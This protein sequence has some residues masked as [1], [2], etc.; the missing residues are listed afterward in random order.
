METDIPISSIISLQSESNNLYSQD[1]ASSFL[2]KW[3]GRPSDQLPDSRVGGSSINSGEEA[4][5]PI[6]GGM[7]LP[8]A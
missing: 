5:I 4:E 3:A 8:S 7:P 6:I 2:D 1:R